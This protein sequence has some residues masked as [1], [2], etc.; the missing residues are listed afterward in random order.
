MN[1]A[2]LLDSHDPASVTVTPMAGEAN[3]VETRSR[4]YR[5]LAEVIKLAQQLP[6][7]SLTYDELRKCHDSIVDSSLDSNGFDD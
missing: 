5:P 4:T 2:K 6:Q 1:T 3:Q 7:T